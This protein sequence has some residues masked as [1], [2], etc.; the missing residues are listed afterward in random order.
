[1]SAAQ[2]GGKPFQHGWRANVKTANGSHRGAM[3]RPKLSK[4]ARNRPA[5]PAIRIWSLARSWSRRSCSDQESI[6]ELKAPPH[7][8]LMQLIKRHELSRA[9]QSGAR[10]IRGSDMAG[11]SW[12]CADGHQEHRP[13][14]AA[15]SSARGCVCTFVVADVVQGEV[16]FAE[17]ESDL[18]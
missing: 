13:T 15:G 10:V 14:R 12:S 1:M 18:E 8:R 4:D 6:V 2:A 9:G 16:A 5:G 3:C 17:V 7:G 11:R